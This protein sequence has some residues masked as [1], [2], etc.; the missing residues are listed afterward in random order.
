[1]NPVAYLT[2]RQY[3]WARRHGI[4]LDDDGYVE[5]HLNDNFF[6]PLTEEAFRE[7]PGGPAGELHEQLYATYSSAALVVNVFFYWRLY[8]ELG[9]LLAVL[10]PNLVDFEVQGTRFEARC[11]IAWPV[12]PSQPRTPPQLDV[13]IHYAHEQQ[14]G[15]AK[16]I[17]VESK[18]REP[19]GA[20]RDE[21]APCY[22]ANENIDMWRGLEP[23]HRLAVEIQEGGDL[24]QRLHV[25]QLIKHVL[26]LNSQFKGAQNFELL[27]L[28]TPAPGPEAVQLEDEIGRFRKL[29][30]ACNPGISFRAIRY[31]DLI[32]AL[33]VAHGAVHGAY[34]DYLVER[35]F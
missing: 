19:Y 35:Y 22:L 3:A 33:A 14:P 12:P 1:M 26:G 21:F 27:Y 10:C 34:V 6:L 7:F 32:Q 30:D 28:W 9:P 5:Q 29:T 2:E 11:P 4:K 31:D 24:Y 15:V 18:F 16:A 23:L 17:A 25:A 13:L 8:R 20:H